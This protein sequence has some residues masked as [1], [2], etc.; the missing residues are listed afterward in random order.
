MSNK[1]DPHAEVL[2]VAKELAWIRCN[3][4]KTHQARAPYWLPFADELDA[5]AFRL[6]ALGESLTPAVGAEGGAGCSAVNQ[7]EPG[8]VVGGSPAR[9]SIDESEAST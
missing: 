6:T 8:P 4:P 7:T 5:L 2:A 9:A 3:L 1:I